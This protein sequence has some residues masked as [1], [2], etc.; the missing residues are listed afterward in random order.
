MGNKVLVIDDSK[1]ARKEIVRIIHNYGVL[2]LEAE[3]GS[4][5]IEVL[6][7]AKDNVGLVLCD[8]NMPVMNGLE[9]LENVKSQDIYSRLPIVMVT[10]EATQEVMKSA[11]DLGVTGW[12]IKPADHH[13]VHTLLDTFCA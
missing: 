8:I 4:H 7:A 6:D 10:S 13:T 2:T 3:N 12:I 11:K 1:T 9:F 5:G